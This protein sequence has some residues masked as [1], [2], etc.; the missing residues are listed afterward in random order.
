MYEH[1]SN[2][3]DHE[4]NAGFSF[5]GSNGFFEDCEQNGAIYLAQQNPC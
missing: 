1:G 5:H 4:Q 3:L 2:G